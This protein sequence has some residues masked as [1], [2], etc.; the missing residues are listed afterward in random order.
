MFN[1]K[2]KW[3]FNKVKCINNNPLCKTPWIT[4]EV[5]TE[6]TLNPEEEKDNTLNNNNPEEDKVTK[7]T[8][9]TT[10]NKITVVDKDNNL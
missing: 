9:I 2:L 5:I 8:T 1:N 6:T 3:L 10:D 7:T 4:S